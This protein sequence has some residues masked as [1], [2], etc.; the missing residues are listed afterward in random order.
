MNSPSV[1][2]VRKSREDGA[3]PLQARVAE[4]ER[5]C[6]RLALENEIL[7]K[8]SPGTSGEAAHNDRAGASGVSRGANQGS[9]RAV[10]GEPLLVLRTPD[11]GAQGPKRCPI[12][13]RH[14]AGCF[15]VSGLRISSG[16]GGLEARLLLICNFTSRSKALAT[17]SETRFSTA[18]RVR[19]RPPQPSVKGSLVLPDSSTQI[20]FTLVYSFRTSNPFSKP[21][22]L[23]L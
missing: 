5:F 14:R 22:P 20:D 18:L 9:V 16:Y 2:K 6:G 10:L 15:G 4:L 21:R 1:S 19:N 3:N 11:S 12:Q 23:I 17:A 7:K 13:R 8:G